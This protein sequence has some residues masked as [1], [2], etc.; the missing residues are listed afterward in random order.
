GLDV[1][2]GGPGLDVG[3]RH[4]ASG[5]AAEQRRLIGGTGDDL[6][7]G[8]ELVAIE[9]GIE[10]A[11]D[12]AGLAV[13]AVAVLCGDGEGGAGEGGVVRGAS[14]QRQE[15]D[16]AGEPE[17]VSHDCA[18]QRKPRSMAPPVYPTRPEG[19]SIQDERRRGKVYP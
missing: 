14:R 3:G 5:H 10:A 7:A 4:L 13:T 12:G 1:L 11:L 6:L 18:P 2:G 9:D 15:E 17:A 8:D 16:K 19:S